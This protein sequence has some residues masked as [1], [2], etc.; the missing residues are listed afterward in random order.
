M[1]LLLLPLLLVVIT[2]VVAPVVTL[3]D[4]CGCGVLLAYWPFIV[5]RTGLNEPTLFIEDDKEG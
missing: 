3:L 5:V 1:C 4:K 2:A